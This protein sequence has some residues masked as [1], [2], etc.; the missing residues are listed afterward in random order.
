MELIKFENIT[1]YFG[2]NAVLDSLSLSVNKGEFIGLI[3]RSGGGKT[4][5]LRVLIGF[6]KIDSG[7]VIFN[8]KDITKKSR[9]I[10]KIMGFCTQENSFYPQ[11]TVL[12]NLAYYGRMYNVKGRILKQRIKDLL[13]LTKLEGSENTLAKDISGGM[14]RRLDFAISLTHDPEL[15]VFDE[16]TTGLDP[17]LEEE[18]WEL[19]AKI[20]KAGKTIVIISHSLGMMENYCEKIGI[21]HKGKIKKIAPPQK[22]K[23]LYKE[24]NLVNIFEKMTKNA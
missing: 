1:K 18:I 13:K 9:I 11:L 22:L 6:Y 3:G 7:R 5:L 10:K 8:E 17:V 14:K 23:E 21:L 16:P 4:T 20:N 2:D 15:L 19:M 12:E 24:K